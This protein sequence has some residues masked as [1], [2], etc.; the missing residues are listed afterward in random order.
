M[1]ERNVSG[2]LNQAQHPLTNNTVSLGTPAQD[3]GRGTKHTYEQRSPSIKR[4][5][6]SP[7]AAAEGNAIRPRQP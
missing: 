5:A 1:K 6:L 2:L 7:S 4:Q 3:R